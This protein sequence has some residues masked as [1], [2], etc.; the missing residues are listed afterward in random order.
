M[1]AIK[2]SDCTLDGKFQPLRGE[3]SLTK[4]ISVLMQMNKE[5][6]GLNLHCS[7]TAGDKEGRI[8]G[9]CGGVLKW[10]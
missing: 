2:Q 3:H 4:Q 6:A 1:S 5:Q 8:K 10:F 9:V 7:N